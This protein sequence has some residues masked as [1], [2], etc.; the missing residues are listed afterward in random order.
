MTDMNTPTGAGSK[1]PAGFYADDSGR[2][3]WFDGDDWTDHYQS[4]ATPAA[5][6]HA[7]P[8]KKKRIFLWFFM[9]V[10]V[11]FIIWIIAGA[12]SSGGDATDC[13][14]LSQQACNDAEDIGTGL[15]VALIVVFWIVVDF[16]LAV[17]YGIYRLAKRN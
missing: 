13:G 3:R 9:A 16:L 6:S 7:E 14:S 5:S 15:G 8:K 11:L 12:G 4:A 10:Q 2:Q 17:I 1:P